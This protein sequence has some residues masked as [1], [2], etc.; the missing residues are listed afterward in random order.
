M[1]V[2]VVFGTYTLRRGV[3]LVKKE[4]ASSVDDLIQTDI[5]YHVDLNMKLN[6]SQAVYH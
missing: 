1:N 6:M 5:R 2:E 3:K 4:P